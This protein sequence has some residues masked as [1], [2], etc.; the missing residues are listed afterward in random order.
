[1]SGQVLYVSDWESK[2]RQSLNLPE[3]LNKKVSVQFVQDKNKLEVIITDE[4]AGFDWRPYMQI[5]P[6][7]ATQANGRGIAKANLLSFD[8]LTYLGKGNQVRVVSAR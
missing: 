5:E 4:G 1:M 6:S 2:V 7:R 3:N 8:E